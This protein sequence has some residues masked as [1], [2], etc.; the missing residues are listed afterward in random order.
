VCIDQYNNIYPVRLQT[1]ECVRR[2]HF[3]LTLGGS[4]SAMSYNT[5]GDAKVPEVNF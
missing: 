3:S 5:G 2:K 4:S 1:N